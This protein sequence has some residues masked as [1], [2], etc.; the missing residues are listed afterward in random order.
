MSVRP[1][2]RSRSASIQ[3]LESP[4]EAWSKSIATPIRTIRIGSSPLD[5]PSSTVIERDGEPRSGVRRTREG[6]DFRRHPHSVGARS[7]DRKARLLQRIASSCVE[8]RHVE[9]SCRSRQEGR[10]QRSHRQPGAQREARGER[11]HPSGRA[12]RA[13]RA[14]LRAPEQAA[15]GT[16]PPGRPVPARAARTR[17]SPPSASS[18]ARGLA[19]HGYTPVLCTQTVGGI[20]EADYV[21][22]LLDQHVSGVVF[23]GGQYTQEDAP[24]EHYQRLARPAACR[25]CS[26]TPRSPTSHFPTVSTDDA[27]AIEQAWSH[28]VQLGHRRIG[29]VLGPGR[30]HPVAPQARRRPPG[31]RADR[32]PARRRAGRAL[33]LLARGRAGGDGATAR[34][35]RHRR[36]LRVRPA[37][38]RR[39]P[40]GASRRQE[41]ARRRLDRRLRRLGAH[42]QHRPAADDGPPA[43]RADGPHGHRAAGQPAERHGSARGRVSLRARARRPGLD[44][45]RAFS[46]KSA[47]VCATFFRSV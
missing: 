33:A 42:E 41:R 20:S 37:R 29:L 27:V 30:P 43:D 10:S 39:R 47:Q 12:H 18:S 28:L 6:H 38:A 26:S 23:V 17:S 44:R 32:A 19:Q 9:T 15:R 40:R 13:R 14:R 8:F 4:T 1:T 46:R 35:R 11:R 7:V 24:H 22:L 34:I 21:E 3:S 31:R 45:P 5:T 2:A 16:R 36:H 25:R